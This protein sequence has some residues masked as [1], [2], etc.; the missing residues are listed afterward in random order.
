MSAV[1]AAFA[2]NCRVR[3]TALDLSQQAVSEQMRTLGF[4]WHQTV[5]AK[6]E[7]G[8]RT[9][10]LDEAYALATI[11]HTRLSRLSGVTE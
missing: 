4:P 1:A 9:V 2:Q 7:S 3:R 10:K 8:E 11:L 6:I 5:I